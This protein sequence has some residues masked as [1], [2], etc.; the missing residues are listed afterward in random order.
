MND[1]RHEL[2]T[3]ARDGT[4]HPPHPGASSFRYGPWHIARADWIRPHPSVDWDWWHEDYDGPGDNRCGS[5]GTRDACIA[6]IHEWEDEH[7]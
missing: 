7:A 5:A 1:P 3:V 2:Y 6:E 4:K